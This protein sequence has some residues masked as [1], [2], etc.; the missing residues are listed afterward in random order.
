[1]GNKLLAPEAQPETYIIHWC[2]VYRQRVDR[3]HLGPLC[4]WG[5]NIQVTGI[6]AASDHVLYLQR[7]SSCCRDLS[8]SLKHEAVP[9]T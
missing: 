7:L 2:T 3:I 1:M 8:E 6:Q 5:S 9:W 4:L